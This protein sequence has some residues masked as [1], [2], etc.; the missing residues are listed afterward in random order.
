VV[1]FED[2][3]LS[4]A[5]TEPAELTA[6]VVFFRVCGGLRTLLIS[7]ELLFSER[8]GKEYGAE[9]ESVMVEFAV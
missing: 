5:R 4:F 3:L 1:V 6:L 8:A 9:M 7:V 2:G